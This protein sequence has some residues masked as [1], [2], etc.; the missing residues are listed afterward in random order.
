[1][2]ELAER[3]KISIGTVIYATDFSRC[4]QNA[5]AYAVRLAA[6]LSAKLV[7]A[8]AFTLTQAAMEV[9][10][11]RTSVSRQRMELNSLLA[12]TAFLLGSH[13]I[14]AIPALLDGDP[15]D[16]LP[17]LAEEHAPSMIVLGTHG[18]VGLERGLLGSVAEKVL[19]ST[20]WPSLTVGP[21]VGSVSVST[22]PFSRILFATDFSPA[23]VQAAVFTASFAETLGATIDVLNVAPESS[24]L[25]AESFSDME[26]RFLGELD[27]L[28]PERAKKFCDPRTYVAMG[29]AHDRILD[30][31]RER[32]ID[33]LVL[34]IRK[35]SHLSLEI[36]TSQAF[37]I[38]AD[39]D[40]PV[41]TIRR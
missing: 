17:T 30:H 15:E 10:A 22:V 7:V 2:V 4:S 36:R 8:H 32:S 39:A 24:V 12:N 33:L 11:D 16:V 13:G 27:R 28:M 21:H 19:R 23:A 25:E 41:L 14:A 34:G 6:F 29:N 5:G 26:E 9:E 3:S 38:I 37:R 18:G 20:D 31:I 35:T 1:M 40:C